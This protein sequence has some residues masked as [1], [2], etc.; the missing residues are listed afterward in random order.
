LVNQCGY[1][2]P[3]QRKKELNIIALVS[4]YSSMQISSAFSCLLVKKLHSTKL[5]KH[6]ALFILVVI[7]DTRSNGLSS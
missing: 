3:K 7:K 6:A 4:T 2:I 5:Y 1:Y